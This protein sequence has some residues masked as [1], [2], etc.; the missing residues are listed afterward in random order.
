MSRS[1][2]QI[3]ACLIRRR[4][5][6][7]ALAAAT[8]LLSVSCAGVLTKTDERIVGDSLAA[9]IYELDRFDRA[10]PHDE[11]AYKPGAPRECA[12]WAKIL[13]DWMHANNVASEVVAKGSMPARERR[14][15][16]AFLKA[17]TEMPK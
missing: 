10:C 7:A 12:A 17:T 6:R 4:E 9:R 5:A 11:H 14:E 3:G 8:I 2:G 16:R 15:L 1:A 13:N